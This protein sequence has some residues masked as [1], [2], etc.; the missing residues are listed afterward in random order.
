MFNFITGLMSESHSDIQSR[1]LSKLGRGKDII[2]QALTNESN[3]LLSIKIDTMLV[4]NPNASLTTNT[5]VKKEKEN[6]LQIVGFM[7]T[8][9][10]HIFAHSRNVST[11]LQ[12]KF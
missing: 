11:I 3:T 2:I 5:Q 8:G 12:I 7:V 6:C 4:Q 1:Q 10:M 9:I